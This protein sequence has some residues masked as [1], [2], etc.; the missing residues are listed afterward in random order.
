M[1][2]AAL[3]NSYSHKSWVVCKVAKKD[4]LIFTVFRHTNSFALSSWRAANA[5]FAT[6]GWPAWYYQDDSL[7][8]AAFLIL[9]DANWTMA[10]RNP[11]P[12][13]RPSLD[14]PSSTIL[15]HKGQDKWD[16][17]PSM[18]IVETFPSFFRYVMPTW[19]GFDRSASRQFGRDSSAELFLSPA[20]WK[21]LCNQVVQR[22]QRVLDLCSW[23]EST[24]TIVP[25]K[26]HPFRG[27]SRIK[28]AFVVAA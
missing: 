4:F 9:F 12:N 8:G 7:E 27:N 13:S 16:L 2:V 14:T 17:C 1:L 26:R 6:L 15:C 18:V 5:S 22:P 10:L 11:S 3:A 23:T 25:F 24:F 19:F 21:S 20:G 28:R